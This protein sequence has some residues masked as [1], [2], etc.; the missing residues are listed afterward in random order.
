L[1]YYKNDRKY[2]GI[3]DEGGVFSLLYFL[4]FADIIYFVITRPYHVN[5][6]DLVVYPTAQA[7]PTILNRE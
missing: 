2:T 4:L 5:I 7:T 6:E 3:H 1:N